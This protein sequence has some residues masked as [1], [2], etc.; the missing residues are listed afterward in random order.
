MSLAAV[1]IGITQGIAIGQAHLLQKS[2]FEIT[3]RSVTPEEVAGEIERFCNA[4][5]QARQSLS[6]VREQIPLK[7]SSDII[8]FID[9]HLL[10]LDDAALV[11]API[12]LI[13][14]KHHCAEWALQLQRDALVAVFDAM[15]DP[16]LRTRKDDVDHVV[17]QIHKFL[18][19]E[20]EEEES[21][22]LSGR[23]ILA[24][25]LTPA[26]TI[27]MR[28]QGIAAFVTEFGGPMSHTAILARS[29]GIPAVVGV[30]NITRHLNA[31]DVIEIGLPYQR[32]TGIGVQPI[33]FI[34]NREIHLVLVIDS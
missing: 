27:L 20:P 8:A 30:K 5:E 16:Y 14:Q 4:V 34:I 26:D 21:G 6:N 19:D 28:H 1:G 11:E 17:N 13:K 18:L 25:D 2:L 10:M 24:H 32:H 15:E 33:Y 3:P 7:T 22:D 23:V 12:D 31:N 9:T 29:L